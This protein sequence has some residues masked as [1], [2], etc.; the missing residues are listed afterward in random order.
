MG[1]IANRPPKLL[2]GWGE[3]EEEHTHGANKPPHTM[4]SSN[5]LI[6]GHGGAL[7]EEAQNLL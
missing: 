3:H 6:G 4:T 2:K 7:V 5:L 1:R